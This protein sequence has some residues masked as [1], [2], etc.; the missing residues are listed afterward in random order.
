MLSQ[1]LI[2]L[3][4]FGQYP[5]YKVPLNLAQVEVETHIPFLPVHRPLRAENE[6]GRIINK[7]N[8]NNGI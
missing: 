7:N 3:E 1:H 6:N 8:I 5:E 2:S 4:S